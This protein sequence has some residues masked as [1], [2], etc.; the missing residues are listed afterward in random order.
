MTVLRLFKKILLLKAWLLTLLALVL[1]L[2]GCS[3][4]P[5]IQQI[6][7][8]KCLEFEIARWEAV[9]SSYREYG[10]TISYQLE[11]LNKSSFGD[12]FS[13]CETYRP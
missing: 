10:S 3:S 8:E 2:S 6:N 9:Q 5:S 1:A 7:Y 4:S 11:T 12:I 13:E